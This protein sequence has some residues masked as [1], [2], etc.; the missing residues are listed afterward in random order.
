MGYAVFSC[1]EI[2][3]ELRGEREYVALLAEYF[4][5]CVKD[6]AIDTRALSALVFADGEARRKLNSLSHPLIM[7]RLMEKMKAHAVAFAEV[8]LL[9]EGGFEGLFDGTVAVLRDRASRLAAVADRDGFG[10][11]EILARMAAQADER[12][13]REKG[14]YIVVNEGSL[15]DLRKCAVEMTKFYKIG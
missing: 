2:Y 6:G 13:Y 11:E 14:A 10:E 9:Y 7:Q 12:V 3:R 4:P 15:D 5:A 1:D 8:P